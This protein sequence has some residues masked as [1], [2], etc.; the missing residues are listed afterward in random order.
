MTNDTTYRQVEVAVMTGWM[1]FLPF[2]CFYL[3]NYGISLKSIVVFALKLTEWS[4]TLENGY[5]SAVHDHILH[6]DEYTL[7]ICS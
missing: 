5:R 7:K 2:L 4:L 1:F 6:E 3:V